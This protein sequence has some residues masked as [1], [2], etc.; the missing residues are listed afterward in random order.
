MTADQPSVTIIVPTLNEEGAIVECLETLQ[1]QDYANLCQILVLDGMSTDRT[2]E[3]AAAFGAPVEVHENP[4]VIIATAM[5]RGLELARGEIVCKADAHTHFADDYL[6]KCVEVLIETGAD[7]VG[8][9]MRA[10]GTTRFGRAVAAV[11]SSPLGIGP[12]RFHYAEERLEV[13][14]VFQGCWWKS[15]LVEL[16]GWDG[17][18]L[19]WAAEDDE[20]NY[21]I[22]RRG[23]RIMLDPSI[24]S[25]YT[26]RQT[27][28]ALWR[29]YR[30]YGIAKTS[31]LAKHRTLPYWR[32]LVPAGFVS[33]S[34]V[35]ALLPVRWPLRIAIPAAHAA[36]AIAVACHLASKDDV[37]PIAAF[38]AIEVC[39]WSYGT[40]FLAG[41]GRIATGRGFGNTKAAGKR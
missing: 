41:L 22:R 25:W 14:T 27:P 15:Y 11:T 20:L 6:R 35:A 33:A 36:F 3:L 17:R 29:Q 2:V 4:E 7:N 16:G 1:R 12:G 23:G 31:S 39:H 28:R 26:P 32:P 9:L 21:R 8:G 13:D 5:N 38:A 24:L 19:H 37:D 30:N 18:D 34:A 40:G 10:V